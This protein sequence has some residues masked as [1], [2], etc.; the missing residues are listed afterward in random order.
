MSRRIG[1]DWRARVRE[2]RVAALN[3]TVGEYNAE[4]MGAASA[5]RM[6]W[7]LHWLGRFVPSSLAML[8]FPVLGRGFAARWLDARG[9]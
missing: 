1:A 7:R 4:L 9:A 8:A 5:W 6:R 2:Q 3:L